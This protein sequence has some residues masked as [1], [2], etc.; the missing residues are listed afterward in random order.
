[1][2]THSKAYEWQEKEQGPPGKIADWRPAPSTAQFIFHPGL[3]GAQKYC[4][5]TSS[6]LALG[7]MTEAWKPGSL[8]KVLVKRKLVSVSIE[9]YL[10]YPPSPPVPPPAAVSIDP[11]VP[12]TRLKGFCE[13]G[14]LNRVFT[15]LSF[16]FTTLPS[17]FTAL[18][19]DF[20]G[21]APQRLAGP[22]ELYFGGIIEIMFID[23][24]SCWTRTTY[25]HL[26]VF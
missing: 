16:I 19:S 23:P 20:I 3:L 1:M 11:H 6:L 12:H 18:P 10:Q 15:A 5:E 24:V 9:N 21:P 2:S 4:T 26:T 14:K 13:P 8:E 22:E 7:P 25:V 17:V